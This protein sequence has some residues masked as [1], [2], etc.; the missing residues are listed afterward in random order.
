MNDQI[1]HNTTTDEY[2][3]PVDAQGQPL[4]SPVLAMDVP[5]ADEEDSNL[6]H[7]SLSETELRTPGGLV[8]VRTKV[9]FQPEPETGNDIVH[10][11]VEQ[12]QPVQQSSGVAK[13]FGKTCIPRG[14]SIV[15]D[16]DSQVDVT[17]ACEMHG[18]I[19]MGGVSKLEIKQGASI[20]A[21]IKAMD[22]VVQ[23][24]VEGEIDAGGGSVSIEEGANIRGKVSYSRIRMEGGEHQMELVHVPRAR[25]TGLSA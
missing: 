18:A 19:E 15:G 4:A 1:E 13:P 6:P 24:F 23:G 2:Q 7:E 3:G 12:A 8:E 20:V 25:G 5:R 11:D 9:P 22:V 14:W 16:I 10:R 17:L 21:K